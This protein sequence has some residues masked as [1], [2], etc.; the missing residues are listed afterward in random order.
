MEKCVYC[1]RDLPEKPVQAKVHTRSF[2]V[3]SEQCRTRTEQYVKN[4]KRFKTAMYLLIF[5]GGTGFV[6]SAFFGGTDSLHMLGAYIGQLVAGL[7]FLLMP[8]P[9]SSFESFHSMSIS[10]VT[11]LTRII[12]TVL[13]VSAVVLLAL[14]L[15]GQ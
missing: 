12:G 2:E 11:R 14:T 5:V 7:A 4:D 3:C 1:G 15:C 9:V 6:I 8:Y 13:S 10:G